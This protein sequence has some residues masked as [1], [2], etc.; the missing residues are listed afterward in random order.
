MSDEW[1]Y[2]VR[3]NLNDDYAEVARRDPSSPAIKPI[4]KILARHNATLKNQFDAFAEYVRDAERHGVEHFPLYKW[5][6]VTIEDPVKKAKHIRSFAIHVDENEVYEK[7]IADA[8]ETDLQPLLAEGLITGLS[9]R[10]TNPA[11]NPQPP[12]HLR[13]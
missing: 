7:E 8:L 9:K 4:T 13:S 2:Q 11:N 1:K 6:K 10:D 12:A 3:I 5:T